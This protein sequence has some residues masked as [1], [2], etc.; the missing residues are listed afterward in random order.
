[1]RCRRAKG[2][3]PI[4]QYNNKPAFTL[5]TTLPLFKSALIVNHWRIVQIEATRRTPL[6]PRSRTENWL[7]RAA[8][9]SWSTSMPVQYLDADHTLGSTSIPSPSRT[10]Q[11][12]ARHHG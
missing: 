2:P 1:M 11:P 6:R 12:R 10:R 5:L 8:H 9:H 3:V 4:C 7:Q